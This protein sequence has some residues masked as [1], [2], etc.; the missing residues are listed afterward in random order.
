MRSTGSQLFWASLGLVLTFTLWE[1]IPLMFNIPSVI[2]PRFSVVL[3][4]LSTEFFPILTNISISLYRILIGFIL[5]SI[6]GVLLGFVIGA[7]TTLYYALYPIL[8]A[9]YTIPKQ[10]MIPLLVLWVGFGTPTAII[11]SVLTSFFPVL[12]NVA[13][14]FQ[15]VS[16]EMRELVYINGGNLLRLFYKVSIPSS[17]P[18]LFAGMKVG[19]IGAIVGVTLAEMLASKTGVGYQIIMSLNA[20]KISLL[21]SYV[22][23]IT[24]VSLILYEFVNV[25]DKRL[26]WWAYKIK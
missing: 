18:Y 12:V 11:T 14:A 7:S 21:F 9:I 3:K 22:F 1:L 10:A 25:F 16:P 13:V 8:I 20:F 6:S 26:A 5:G 19:I 23:I 15:T 24:C 17:L 4:T 2:L